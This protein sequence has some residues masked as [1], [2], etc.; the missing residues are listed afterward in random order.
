MFDMYVVLQSLISSVGEYHFIPLC[1]RYCLRPHF[2]S[3]IHY[4]QRAADRWLFRQQT[5]IRLSEEEHCA[6]VLSVK[7]LTK[8]S[9]ETA[10]HGTTLSITE[11][12]HQEQIIIHLICT[13]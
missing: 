8:A 13:G 2:L 1:I 10:Q 11:I 4:A 6:F 7:T 9:R 3:F 5:S 12:M